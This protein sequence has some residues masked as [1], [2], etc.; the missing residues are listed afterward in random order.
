MKIEKSLVGWYF[1]L[2]IVILYAI[3]LVLGKSIS[4]A[5]QFAANI[6]IKILPIFGLIFIIMLIINYFIEPKTLAKYLGK[7][8]G[9][10]GWLI[11]IAAGIIST[12]PIFLW[13]PL[14]AELKEKGMRP[15]FIATFLYNRAIKPALIPLMV[16]YFSWKFVAILTVVMI[17]ASIFEGWL[18]EKILEVKI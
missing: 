12:G 14:L 9:V 16:V 7:G 11:S 1:L 13:Y 10:K 6:T 18:V 2:A 3:L 4:P 8:S 5:L 15:A 17:F